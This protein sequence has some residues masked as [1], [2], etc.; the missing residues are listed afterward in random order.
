MSI[1]KRMA[2]SAAGWTGSSRE[3][4]RAVES[5]EVRLCKRVARRGGERS[6]ANLR[7][8]MQMGEIWL[9]LNSF[10]YRPKLNPWGCASG[11]IACFQALGECSGSIA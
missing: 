2:K 4:G 3:V 7:A 8:G 1:R 6:V 5:E 10:T 11:S 9:G